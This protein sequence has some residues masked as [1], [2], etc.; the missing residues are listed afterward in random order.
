[1]FFTC[2]VNAA[3][4]DTL[5]ISPMR[6]LGVGSVTENSPKLTHGAGQDVFIAYFSRIGF[7]A[8]LRS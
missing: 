8:Y 3:G 1:M 4:I 7:H 6:Q 5:E 2:C